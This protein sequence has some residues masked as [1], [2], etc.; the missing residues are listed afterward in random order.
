MGTKLSLFGTVHFRF[1]KGEG[2]RSSNKQ[3]LLSKKMMETKLLI[4][5]DSHENPIARESTKPWM[6]KRHV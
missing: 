6:T 5:K 4:K 2:G 3:L 1:K